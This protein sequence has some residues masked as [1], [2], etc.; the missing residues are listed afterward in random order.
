[1]RTAMPTETVAIP[2]SELLCLGAWKDQPYQLRR[3]K[4]TW[5][6]SGYMGNIM[7]SN[8]LLSRAIKKIHTA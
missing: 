8:S 1:M 5:E 6:L 4:R 7:T 2:C 3:A